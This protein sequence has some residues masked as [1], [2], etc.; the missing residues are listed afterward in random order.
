[1][2]YAH[3]VNRSR[4]GEMNIMSGVRL[5]QLSLGKCCNVVFRIWRRDK[6]VFVVLAVLVTYLL[7]YLYGT[8]TMP[9][10][11]LFVNENI[12]RQCIIPDLDPFDKS[13]M[14][15]VWSPDPIHCDPAPDLVYV[16][17]SG[18]VTYNQSAYKF[19]GHS[20][21][22]CSYTPLLRPKNDDYSVQFGE[23]KVSDIPFQVPH[24]FYRLRCYTSSGNKLVYDTL[25]ESVYVSNE[26]KDTKADENGKNSKYSVFMFGIDSTSRLSAIRKLPKTYKYLIEILGAYVFK[27]YMKVGDNTFPNIV[28]VLTGK[29][30]GTVDLPN[31]GG[32]PFDLQP[33]PFIWYNFSREHYATFYAEDYPIIATFNTEASGFKSPPTDHYMRPWMLGLRKIGF[34]SE[35]LKSVLL[36]LEYKNVNMGKSSS[37]CY[38]NKPIFTHL[39]N[40]YKRFVTQYKEKLKF[41]FSWLVQICHEFINYLE[42]GDNDFFEFFKFL[43]ENGHLENAFLIFFSDHGSR[44]DDIRNTFVGRIEE[45]MPLLSIVPP[46]TFAAKHPEAIKNLRDNTDR[47]TSN[48]DLH[49]LLNDIVNADFEA[50]VEFKS[51]TKR[52]ISL[53]RPIPDTR[54]C[55][56]ASIPEHFCACYGSESIAVTNPVVA[57]A[58]EYA[59][60]YL[61]NLLKKYKHI[62]AELSLYKIHEARLVSLGLSAKGEEENRWTIY[63]F[64]SKPEAEKHK[65]FLVIFE[66]LP[67]NAMFEATVDYHVETGMKITDDI[68]RTNKYGN[69]SSCVPEKPLRRYCYC[70]FM[71]KQ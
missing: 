38:G 27:G 4:Q 44:I 45:R 63:K 70:K 57:K 3:T 58:T 17:E 59:V 30:P 71:L 55:A 34:A 65:R 18:F 69:T 8:L 42:L 12:N 13:I 21:Y 33:F 9:V 7:Y 61:N 10:R 5:A 1:M 56:D 66:T 15:Y 28:P 49:E 26:V 36:P 52:G 60:L 39:I 62:C 43:K 6:R 24:D 48:F 32:G 54:S 46:E 68:S 41:S 11:F 35:V 22:K 20:S 64:F 14:Q 40:Y 16:D 29:R 50:S 51:N 37:L 31:P 67:G 19:Y 2:D 47:L 53:F 25:Q 23:E